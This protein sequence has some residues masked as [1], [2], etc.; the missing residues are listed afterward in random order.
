[1]PILGHDCNRFLTIRQA[2]AKA[3][4]K[5]CEREIVPK[6]N[7]HV[8]HLDDLLCQLLPRSRA[9]IKIGTAKF[10][11]RAINLKIA[12]TEEQA[13]YRCFMLDYGDSVTDDILHHGSEGCEKGTIFLC[14]FPGLRRHIMKEKKEESLTVVKAG[15]ELQA[16]AAVASLKGSGKPEETR[17]KETR[18]FCAEQ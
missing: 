13:V 1:M 11:D 14:T 17:T 9:E 2:I 18:S 10:L 12:M 6:R 15:V 5:S 8:V 7:A 4:L 16:T 3:V